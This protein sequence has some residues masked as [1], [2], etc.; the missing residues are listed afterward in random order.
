MPGRDRRQVQFQEIAVLDRHARHLGELLAQEFGQA[1][2]L[3]DRDQMASPAGEERGQ[4]PGSRADLDDDVVVAHVGVLHD[5]LGDVGSHEE[6]L[7]EA[8]RRREA[9]RFE[10]LADALGAVALQ[11]GALPHVV[12]DAAGM[13]RGDGPAAGA[14]HA[15]SVR[16]AAV[17]SEMEG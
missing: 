6:V 16:N 1:M 13:I 2:V 4:R 7:A 8:S 3:L 9:A 15:G 5:A 11:R 10:D 14:R 12:R 17:P